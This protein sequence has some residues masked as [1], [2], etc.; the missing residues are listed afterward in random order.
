MFAETR[1]VCFRLARGDSQMKVA[2]PNKKRQMSQP[3]MFLDASHRS[4]TAGSRICSLFLPV[5]PAELEL[6]L[7]T[8]KDCSVRVGEEI[9]KGWKLVD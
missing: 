2:F 4:N 7:E 6:H 3:E 9:A 5:P 8:C 1:G